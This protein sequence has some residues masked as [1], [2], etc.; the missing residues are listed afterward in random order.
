MKNSNHNKRHNVRNQDW[1][2]KEENPQDHVLSVANRTIGE[3][4]TG[5]GARITRMNPTVKKVKRYH[6]NSFIVTDGHTTSTIPR[7]WIRI[8]SESRP[9]TTG[10]CR[11]RRGSGGSNSYYDH[12]TTN[13]EMVL[14]KCTQ[15]HVHAKVAACCSHFH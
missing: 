7:R 8:I 9:L 13:T 5:I 2:G 15:V 1:D 11:F 10:R 3:G 12:H 4:I 14:N 6:R